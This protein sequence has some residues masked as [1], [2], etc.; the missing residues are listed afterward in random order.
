M[1]RC[2]NHENTGAETLEVNEVV[3][4]SRKIIKNSKDHFGFGQSKSYQHQAAKDLCCLVY[5]D[6]W[7]KAI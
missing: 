3:L 6:T 4:P 7:N 5:F 1:P 2:W